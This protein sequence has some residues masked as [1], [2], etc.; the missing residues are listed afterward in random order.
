V[1][2][3][4]KALQGFRFSNQIRNLSPR[5]IAWYDFELA[6]FERFLLTRF[7]SKSAD[8]LNLQEIRR[9]DLEAFVSSL[10]EC[11][12]QYQ[13]HTYRAPIAKKLS[14]FTVK[15]RVRAIH[16]LFTWA[17]REKF[18]ESNPMNDVPIPKVPKSF[19]ARYSEDEIRR[20]LKA[21]EGHKPL[22]VRNRA[23]ILFLL[24]TGLR[25]SELCALTLD[26]VDEQ[27]RR[28]HITGKGLKDR[29]VPLGAKTRAELWRYVNVARPAPKGTNVL[30]LTAYGRPLNANKLAHILRAIGKRAGIEHVGAHR[31][32]HTSARLFLRNGGDVASLQLMLGHSDLSTT[33]VY[34][35]M[36][37]E[38]LERTHERASPVDRLGL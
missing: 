27:F 29:F 25:A 34:A 1:L 20:L 16:R 4:S 17:N 32:R 15:T 3:F 37:T 19:K 21:C 7:P 36:E 26:R 2:S 12:T 8:S 30:F 14:P 6:A 5:T 11:E 18:I 9:E 10:Q 33:N 13:H 28:A 35:K 31:F 23:I 22:D 38:D 24:D